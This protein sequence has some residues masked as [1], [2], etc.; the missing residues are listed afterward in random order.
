VHDG[1]LI[2]K[3]LR[4]SATFRYIQSAVNGKTCDEDLHVWLL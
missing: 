2:K 3:Q 1:L 4:I